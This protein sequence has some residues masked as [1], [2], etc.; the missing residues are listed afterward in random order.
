M[1]AM[2]KAPCGR[3]DTFRSMSPKLRCFLVPLLISLCADQ[4]TKRMVM[5]R[6]YYGESVSVIPGFFDLTYVRNPGGAFSFFASGP[7]EL[8]L[9]FFIGTTLVAI[10]LLFVFY[11]R[12]ESDALLSGAALGMILGGA[13]GNLID[14]IAYGEVVDFLDFYIGSFAWPTFNIAD[15]CIVVGVSVL[16]Y[17][18]FMEGR[19]PETNAV[20]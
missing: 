14:R 9:T 16:I 4:I 2:S 6:F 13:V 3:R 19:E 15:S 8:R 17:E 1:F 5:S 7:S 20:A 11:R 12:L 18:M 10:G